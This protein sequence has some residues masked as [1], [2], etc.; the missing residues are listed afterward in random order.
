MEYSK[1]NAIDYFFKKIDSHEMEFS[2]LRKQLESDGFEKDEINTIV[3]QVDKQLIRASELRAAHAIGKNLFYGGLFLA[4]MGVIMSVG[5]YT[6][7]INIGNRFLIAYGPI[8][9]GLIIALS[10]KAKMNRI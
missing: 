2:S 4:I 7:I 1:G 10:G 5:T 9:A 6:G 8:A 3:R